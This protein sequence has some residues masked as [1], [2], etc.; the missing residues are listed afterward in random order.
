MI[1]QKRSDMQYWVILFI[2]NRHAAI[3]LKIYECNENVC[4]IIM[5]LRFN[6]SKNTMSEK[7]ACKMSI[8]LW[9]GWPVTVN[10]IMECVTTTMDL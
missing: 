9:N 5:I 7:N 1:D 6:Y 2:I 8:E 10:S 4:I 3:N